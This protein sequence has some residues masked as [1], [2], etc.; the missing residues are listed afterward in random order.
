MSCE[1]DQR[2]RSIFAHDGC[3]ACELEATKADVERLRQTALN[4]AE[5]SKCLRRQNEPACM[6][7]TRCF[8]ELWDAQNKWWHVCELLGIPADSSEGSF[9]DALRALK[10]EVSDGM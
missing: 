2:C 7:C 9:R 3:C 8:G 4:G 6:Y 5:C 1:H 10:Q